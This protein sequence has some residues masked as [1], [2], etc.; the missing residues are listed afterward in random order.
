MFKLLLESMVPWIW[1]R[2]MWSS[3]IGR[4]FSSPFL[5]CVGYSYFTRY[6][7]WHCLTPTNSIKCGVSI[8]GCHSSQFSPCYPFGA[9]FTLGYF[10]TNF[11]LLT[12]LWNKCLHR[13]AS[14]CCGS[15]NHIQEECIICSFILP[16]GWFKTCTQGMVFRSSGPS[17]HR[18]VYSVCIGVFSSS[19]LFDLLCKMD[20]IVL[21]F[22]TKF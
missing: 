17:C 22:F 11:C 1:C 10:Y 7:G 15:S 18:S 20:I 3:C 2:V 8:L 4:E 14:C 21:I 6:S 9:Q 5:F 16:E 19:I 13:R 12:N